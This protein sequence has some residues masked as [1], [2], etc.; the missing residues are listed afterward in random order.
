MREKFYITTTIPYMSSVP[1]IG[2]TL[3]FIQAD[4]L[5]RHARANGKEVFFLTGS[6]EHG[7]KIQKKALEEKISPKKLVDKIS[8]ITKDFKKTLNLSWD[9]FI[10]TT[11][12]KRHWP[13]VF[14]MWK[15]LEEAKDIYKRT[16]RGLYCS[17]CETFLTDK[18]IEEGKCIIHQKEPEL[19]EEENYFF[20]LSAYGKTIKSKIESGEMKVI[21][22]S[23]A[24]EIL[25][26]ID[27]GLEDVS[28]SRPKEKLSWGIRVPG[29]DSQVIYVW[30]DALTNYISA[31]GYGRDEKE[32]EKWW[33]ADVQVLGKDVAKFHVA[34]WPAML[35][36][37]KLPLPQ[38]LFIHGFINIEGQKISKSLGNVIL[39]NDLVD[40]FGTD[41]VRYYFLREIS[42]FDDGDYSQKRFV[43]RY[44]SDLAKG[45]GNFYARVLGLA[46]KFKKIPNNFSL[47]ELSIEQRIKAVQQNIDKQLDGFMFNDALSEIWSLISVGDSYV[48]EQKPWSEENGNIKNEKTLF[49][50]LILLNAIGVLVGPFLPDTSKKITSSVSLKGKFIKVKKAANLFPRL[51]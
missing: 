24:N 19:V 14:K 4:V 26:L 11:D 45:L 28:F 47:M 15:Q 8:K 16:Y 22:Q 31:I 44:N 18:D 23:K 27:K 43:E 5:A 13:G 17:G 49:N 20:R 7:T 12:K 10:R 6:D 48:N 40:K 33:P 38:K 46:E 25:S 37:A 29:D 35:I 30:A 36:S 2:N 51:E 50:L 42:P 41:P 34:I 1:H 21:P 39:P 9:G 3:E 32:F